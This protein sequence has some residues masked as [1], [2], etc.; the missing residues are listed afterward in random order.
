MP[1]QPEHLL[2]LLRVADTGSLSAA[3]TELN[4]SQPAVTQQLKLLERAVGEPL[5]TRHRAGVTLTRTG[6]GLLPFARALRRAL[7]D[8]RQYALDLRD[9]QAGDVR[10]AASTTLAAFVLPP[11]LATF[12]ARHPGV[13]LHVT[14][15]NSR[16]VTQRLLDG[17]CDL[18]LIEGARPALPPGF[19][20]AVLRQDTLRLVAAPTHPLAGR[21]L[22]PGDLDDLPVVWREP[23][24][25][26]REVARAA[27]ARANV[28]VH[29]V[30]HLAGAEAVKEA[31]LSGL[32]A[33]FLSDLSVR[34]DLERGHLVALDVP[35]PGLS[36]PLQALWPGTR[37]KAADALL[38]LLRSPST[39]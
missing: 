21:T 18:A 31:V 25:G 7:D 4:L 27:L 39:P 6:D 10:V 36:R 3:A 19:G 5:F 30:L 22:Q 2:T 12:H 1:V 32:G 9:L 29:D 23:G 14:S 37:S 20:H 28:R 33:A 13:A 11:A 17:A 24:S 35:L 16:E 15:G 8:A 34:R 26:T 38:T